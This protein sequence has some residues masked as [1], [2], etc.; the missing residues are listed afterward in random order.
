MSVKGKCIKD[1]ILGDSVRSE[2]DMQLLEA[3]QQ[4]GKEFT[5]LMVEK[6][7]IDQQTF[8]AYNNLLQ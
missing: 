4:Q 2:V 8:I 5:V 3:K 1:Y 6:K 7:N